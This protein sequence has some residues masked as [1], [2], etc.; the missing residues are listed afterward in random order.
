MKVTRFVSFAATLAIGAA[1]A[2]QQPKATG[3]AT[4]EVASVKRA[5]SGGPPGD[6]PR[7]M[8]DTPGHFAMRNVSL[9][10]ALEW[11]YDLKDFEISV[12]EWMKSE[13]RYD[14]VAHASYPATN[15]QMRPMLQAL[16]TERFQMKLHRETKELSVYALLPGKGPNKLKPAGS[17]GQTG[18]SGSP[19]GVAFHK[20]PV[21]RLTFM[22]T[23]RMGRP[24][25]DL[26][27]LKG[28]YDFTLDIS[29][30]S[31][32]GPGLADEPQGQS[33]FTAVQNDLGLRLEAQ[34]RP[35]DVL[36]VDSANKV[37]IEN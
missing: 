23:R 14:I 10:F 7:N 1:L 3:P 33:I 17:E 9:R 31:T 34:K 26:T 36:I 29:G 6:I 19:S 28:E 15:D 16:L 22:L 32:T 5:G 18:L 37:P 8:E 25:L 24:V 35:I 13:E 11:A 4:F 21:S 12:P 2:A 20:Q 27:G 30:L